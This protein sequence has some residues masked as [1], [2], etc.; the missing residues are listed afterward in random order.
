MQHLIFKFLFK[1][2]AKIKIQNLNLKFYIQVQNSTCSRPCG[3]ARH[4]LQTTR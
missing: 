1:I 3:S 4:I 2:Q